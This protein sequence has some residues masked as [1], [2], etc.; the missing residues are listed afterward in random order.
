L[1]VRLP[2]HQDRRKLAKSMLLEACCSVESRCPRQ[3]DSTLQQYA[4]PEL[5]IAEQIAAMTIAAG[6]DLGMA[7][8]IILTRRRRPVIPRSAR[9]E[10]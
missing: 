3:C 8:V 7:T 2:I 4:H 5:L 6:F 1:L 10:L 9:W